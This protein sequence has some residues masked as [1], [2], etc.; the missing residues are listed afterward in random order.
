MKT[1]APELR[2][3]IIILASTGPVISTRRSSRSA[4]TGAITQSDSRTAACR[5]EEMGT[6]TPVESLLDGG[7]G[8]QDLSTPIPKLP[9]Q[10]VEEGHGVGGEHLSLQLLGHRQIHKSAVS[11]VR[12]YNPRQSDDKN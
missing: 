1:R 2:A 12:V 5:I 7:S 3:L 11:C 8:L 10:I 6:E 9:F 4:G